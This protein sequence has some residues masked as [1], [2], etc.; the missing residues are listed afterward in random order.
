MN[1][2]IDESTYQTLS[3]LYDKKE[4]S[5]KE[6]LSHYH[7]N[8]IENAISVVSHVLF[9]Y[10]SQCIVVRNLHLTLFECLT[11][12]DYEKACL[13]KSVSLLSPEY[14]L[15]VL[16]KGSVIVEQRRKNEKQ[17]QETIQ[18]LKDISAFSKEQAEYVKSMAHSAQKAAI[19]SHHSAVN[20]EKQSEISRKFADSS[21]EISDSLKIQV[22]N[23][24]KD[25]ESSKRNS[26]VSLVI[27]ILALIVPILGE[28]ITILCK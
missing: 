17:H 9:L 21:K 22:E 28:L 4:C 18:P 14:M 26:R 15:Y 24:I 27:S 6:L 7:I 16:P 5:V 13:T 3:Y 25:L 2:Y 1:D 20:A 8:Q 19:L 12:D 23:Y 10:A 11:F